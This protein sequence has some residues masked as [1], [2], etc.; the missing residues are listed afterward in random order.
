M[1]I[2]DIKALSTM[3]F[4]DAKKVQI[5]VDAITQRIPEW[6]DEVQSYAEVSNLDETRKLCHR[7]RGAA[8]S[9]KAEKLTDAATTLGEMIKDNQLD[10]IQTGFHNLSICLEEVL[11]Q[12][13][14]LSKPE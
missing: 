12:S 6:Q 13:I 9:V 5:V 8:G 11:A 4:N 10:Q 1:H 7:I 14:K 3:L 2:I